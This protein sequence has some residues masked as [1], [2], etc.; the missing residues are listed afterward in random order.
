[1]ML[2]VLFAL[3]FINSVGQA[4]LLHGEKEIR[5]SYDEPFPLYPGEILEGPIRPLQIVQ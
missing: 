3:F 5:F 1:M 4:I 2:K